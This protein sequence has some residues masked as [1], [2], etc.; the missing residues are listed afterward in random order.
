MLNQTGKQTSRFPTAT[1]QLFCSNLL[2]IIF[3]SN[4]LPENNLVSRKLAKILNL[5]ENL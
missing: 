2:K 1:E 5:Q 3:I 4:C